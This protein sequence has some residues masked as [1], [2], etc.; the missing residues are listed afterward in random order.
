M[1]A[2]HTFVGYTAT[3]RILAI[4]DRKFSI[5]EFRN[6]NLLSDPRPSGLL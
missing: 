4:S 1:R 6:G 3:V 5:R 2:D